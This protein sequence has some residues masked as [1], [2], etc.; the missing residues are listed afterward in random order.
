MATALANNRKRKADVLGRVETSSTL[1]RGALSGW[2]RCPLCPPNR[3]KLFALGRGISAHLWAVHTPWNKKKSKTGKRQRSDQT[4]ETEEESSWKPTPQEE[5]A[6]AVRVAEIAAKL[7]EEHQEDLGVERSGKPS[8]SYRES[9]PPF[10]Q[11]AADGNLEK[12]RSMVDQASDRDELS[13]LL[14]TR[15]RNGSTAEHWAAGGGHLC[16]LKFIFEKREQIHK[17]CSLINDAV[18]DRNA[19]GMKLRRRDGKT[20]LHYASRNG[21]LNC[22][23]YLV[24]ERGESVDV[25][26]GDGTTPLHLACYGAKPDTV[27]MLIKYGANV[28]AVNDWDCNAAHWTAMSQSQDGDTIERLCKI[29]H[30]SGISFINR[31]KQGHSALHKAAQKRNRFVIEW[32]AKATQDGGPGLSEKERLD[33]GLSD[34][35][36]HRPSEIWIGVGGERLFAEWIK[37]KFE[38]QQDPLFS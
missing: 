36:G 11:A 25:R 29:L 9:L 8:Q 7:E 1:G 15:D 31:Q 18:L 30:N 19:I 10:I 13:K 6:W 17:N 4:G 38:S 24:E 26:S 37:A 34:Q 33:A 2:T 23:Q 28:K 16:C 3:K 20:C 5:E 27:N 35:G 12:V 22:I 14:S 32:M 21:Q